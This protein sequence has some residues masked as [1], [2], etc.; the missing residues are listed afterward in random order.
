ME[1]KITCGK[2]DKPMIHLR[3]KDDYWECV[4]CQFHVK[5]RIEL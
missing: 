5:P 4:E 1:L 2:C 3:D